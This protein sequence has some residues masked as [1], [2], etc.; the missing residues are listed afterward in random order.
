VY[1]KLH[2]IDI[3]DC[4]KATGA[5]NFAIACP[6]GAE[7]WDY[8][9]NSGVKPEEV[10][11]SAKYYASFVCD[12]DT[13][14]YEIHRI[15]CFCKNQHRLC[16]NCGDN[17][18]A[19]P[20][21]NL[22]LL[23]KDLC[24]DEWDWK[25]N[26]K[27]PWEYTP[28]SKDKVWWN[29]GGEPWVQSISDRVYKGS[30]KASKFNKTSIPELRILC[31]LQS[32]FKNVEWQADVKGFEVD[33]FIPKLNIG[34]EHDGRVYHDKRQRQDEKKRAALAAA[35]IKLYRIRQ[36][37]LEKLQSRDI[38]YNPNQRRRNDIQFLEPIK[39]LL[40]SMVEHGDLDSTQIVDYLGSKSF[41][42]DTKFEELF[43]H[44]PKA[45]PALP[46]FFLSNISTIAGY[47]KAKLLHSR[48][49]IPCVLK[50]AIG[51]RK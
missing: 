20:R 24:D 29:D 15:D 37:P 6:T 48:Q 7:R 31:E 30:T 19:C 1:S 4:P 40:T 14:Y 10:A 13:T 50:R 18:S 11:P 34:V 51:V 21:K 16:P 2:K 49:T 44:L 38:I 46:I 8:D 17:R 36:S 47:K 32:I 25:K 33:V 3:R 35:G 9:R 22:Y 43:Q 39:Q 12:A 41:R 23:H 5:N 42:N 27:N 45:L 28:S 26:K